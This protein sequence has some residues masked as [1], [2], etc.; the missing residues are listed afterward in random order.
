MQKNL[1]ERASDSINIDRLATL[2][3]LSFESEEQR[4]I[5]ADELKKMADYTYSLIQCEDTS[6]PFSYCIAKTSVR[7]DVAH[8]PDAEECKKI[9]ALSASAADGYITV[10]KIIKGDAE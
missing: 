4:G 6:L 7:E 9:L 10:P 1:K 8:M 2:S 3:R 5:A